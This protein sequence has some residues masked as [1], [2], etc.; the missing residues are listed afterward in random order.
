MAFSTASGRPRRRVLEGVVAVAASAS[1][2]ILAACSSR[3]NRRAGGSAAAPAAMPAHHCPSA[4]GAPAARS[5]SARTTRTRSRRA[6]S[7]AR[8]LLHAKTGVT[9]QGQHRRPRHVPG[10]DQ[11]LSPGHARRR[12]HLVRRLPLRFFAAQGLADRHRAT[13]GRRSAATTPTAFKFASTGDD[14]KQYFVP[15]YN[16]PWAVLYRKSLFAGE[17][18]QSRPRSTSSSR[19]PSQMQADGLVPFAFADKDGWPAMG[20]FDILNM[21]H[22]RLRV[23]RRPD[24][25][26]GEVDRPEVTA[27]FK[28]W[29]DLLPF[30]QEGAPAGRGRTPRRRWS[31]RRPACTCSGCSCPSSS[32]RPVSRPPTSTS[33]RSRPRDPVRR[34]EGA[35]TPRSTASC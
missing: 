32:R 4:A 19:S 8:R 30:H 26:Q 21:R 24:G 12:L 17:G 25:R 35:S 27:V 20:T 7:Q 31:R 13:C 11:L 29:K 2:G 10:P 5:P 15:I 14:G 33:S 16:Y 34:R 28:T 6:P 22:Q 3:R 18:L 23:P 9:G 1:S